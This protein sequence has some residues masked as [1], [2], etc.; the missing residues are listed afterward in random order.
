MMEFASGSGAST[1]ISSVGSSAVS[2]FCQSPEKVKLCLL[3]VFRKRGGKGMTNQHGYALMGRVYRGHTPGH[4]RR[5]P[6]G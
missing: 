2:G 6:I 3:V 4:S 1:M 5:M